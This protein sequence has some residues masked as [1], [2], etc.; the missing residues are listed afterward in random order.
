MAFIP[1]HLGRVVEELAGMGLSGKIEV[2]AAKKKILLR[3][4]MKISRGEHRLITQ[5]VINP[6]AVARKASPEAIAAAFHPRQGAKIG[7]RAERGLAP[8]V[9]E[10]YRDFPFAHV[11]RELYMM[12][13]ANPT[14]IPMSRQRSLGMEM[15]KNRSIAAMRAQDMANSIRLNG[16]GKR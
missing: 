10:K 4:G 6:E 1:K 12:E 5:S 2:E 8:A 14:G 16:L 11:E 13:K 9:R 3:E 15:Y 7:T